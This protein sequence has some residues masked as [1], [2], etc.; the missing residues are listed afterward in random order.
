MAVPAEARFWNVPNTLTM[1]RL[2]LAVVVFALIAYG[3]YLSALAVFGIASLTDALDGYFARLLDQGTPLG[4]QLDPL[5]DKVIVSGAYIYLLSVPQTGVQPWM[6]TTI[7]VREML[8]QGLRSHLEGQGQA[9]GAAMAG[10]LKTLVQCLS[11][12]AILLSLAIPTTNNSWIL[13]RDGLTWLAVALTIYSGLGYV[14]MAMPFM[15]KKTS[16]T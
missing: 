13:I 12:S 9:F 15:R 4:R 14:V 7:V 10:K 3:Q 11:I 2:V 5:V 1:S 6:V 8:I 16:T